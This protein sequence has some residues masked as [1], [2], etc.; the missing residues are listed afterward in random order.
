MSAGGMP[1]METAASPAPQDAAAGGRRDRMRW[2]RAVATGL[3]LLF[4]I[5]IGYACW[6]NYFDPPG[7]DFVSFWAAATMALDGQPWLAYD[8]A[9]HRAVELTAGKVDG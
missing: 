7:V 5:Y 9:A 6:R 4:V 3:A 8:V 2:H 1:P